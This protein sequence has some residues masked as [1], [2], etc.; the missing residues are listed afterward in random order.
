MVSSAPS[1]RRCRLYVQIVT[2]TSHGPRPAVTSADRIDAL[3]FAST[4]DARDFPAG[5]VKE[6]PRMVLKK[7][8][9][10]RE[11]LPPL[12]GAQLSANGIHQLFAVRGLPVSDP[13]A[14]RALRDGIAFHRAALSVQ[15]RQR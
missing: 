1:S 13:L 6:P 4:G 10:R 9:Q 11:C 8:D 15:H 14:P 7:A 12:T 5:M 2:V 3:G